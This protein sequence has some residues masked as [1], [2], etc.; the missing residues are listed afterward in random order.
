[1]LLKVLYS[2]VVHCNTFCLEVFRSGQHFFGSGAENFSERHRLMKVKTLSNCCCTG[3]QYP[4]FSSHGNLPVPFEKK[5]V[6]H[7]Y[8]FF[9]SFLALFLLRSHEILPKAG[10]RWALPGFLPFNW[11]NFPPPRE[12]LQ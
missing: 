1:M 11:P 9:F 6:P 8:I 10:L 5:T 12:L 3:Q 4:L 2:E 7:Y